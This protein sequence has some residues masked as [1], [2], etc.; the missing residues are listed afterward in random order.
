MKHLLVICGASGV[1]KTTIQDYLVDKYGFE[2]VITHTTRPQREHEVDGCDYY[3]ETK[4]S[5]FKNNYFEYVEY[6]HCYYGSSREGLEQ[7]WLKSDWAVI[8]LDTEGAATYYEKLKEKLICWY[9]YVPDS[10][11]LLKR[12]ERRDTGYDAAT[13]RLSSKEAKRDM[14]VPPK[15]EHF[16]TRMRNDNWK[17]T[18]E[19]IKKNLIKA[20]CCN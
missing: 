16:C 11:V 13:K 5:F 10:A 3:F 9:I 4:N 17:E 1:G 15:I 19:N 18:E 6:D 7:A 14:N 8:V 2:R 12:L 20:G